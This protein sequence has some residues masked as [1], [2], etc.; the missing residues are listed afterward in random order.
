MNTISVWCCCIQNWLSVYWIPTSTGHMNA[1]RLKLG[2]AI[3]EQYARR[4]P[5]IEMWYRNTL[6]MS[7]RTTCKSRKV[8][9]FSGGM[10]DID[11]CRHASAF[12][13]SRSSF[14]RSKSNHWPVS[15]TDCAR[16]PASIKSWLSCSVGPADT[17]LALKTLDRMF[18]KLVDYRMWCAVWYLVV[19]K[20]TKVI[21][22]FGIAA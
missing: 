8:V 18:G 13:T 7:S 4:W 16:G 19:M 10:T 6:Y 3:P 20:T 5:L 15:E 12:W 21:W 17:V 9:P 1:T 22:C 14:R 2:F 11:R